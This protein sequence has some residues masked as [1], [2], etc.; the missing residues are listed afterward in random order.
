MALDVGMSRKV[1][2]VKSPSLLQPLESEMAELTADAKALRVAADGLRLRALGG[3]DEASV[4]ER[5][6]AMLG[7]CGQARPGTPA[8]A[9]EVEREAFLRRFGRIA[10]PLRVGPA[11]FSLVLSA[12]PIMQTMAMIAAFARILPD[13][14]A[15]MLVADD[16]TD[17]RTR[18]LPM[19]VAGL[20]VIGGKDA[21]SACNLAVAAAR[22][23]DV[24]VLD[25]VPASTIMP[26]PPGVAWIGGAGSLSLARWGMKL[27]RAP[28]P[29]PGLTVAVSVASWRAAG[30]LDANMADGDGLEIADLALRLIDAGLQVMGCD[31]LEARARPSVDPDRQWRC[32]QRFRAR[33]GD[34]PASAAAGPQ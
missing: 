28:A 4:L 6:A 23:G 14:R 8:F 3:P 20:R 5:L 16:S 33:W 11:E 32:V 17:P 2:L 1:D 19:H 31:T 24:V 9:M 34:R 13:G 27:P 22:C 12:D 21:T 18:L 29:Q 15:E 10:L 26:P 25:A 30:G 7:A